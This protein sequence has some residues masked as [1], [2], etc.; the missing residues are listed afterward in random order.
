[1]KQLVCVL[2]A[3]VFTLVSGCA[4]YS[5]MAL[6][7]NP[8]DK[9]KVQVIEHVSK[10]ASSVRLFMLGGVPSAMELISKTVSEANGDGI[11]NLE[12]TLSEGFFGPLTFPKVAIEGD[13]VKVVDHAAQSIKPAMDILITDT[14]TS[15]ASPIPSVQTASKTKTLF[16]KMVGKIPEIGTNNSQGIAQPDS[17]ATYAIEAWKTAI[18]GLNN[19]D[20]I[21]E[22][23]YR[24]LRQT[25]QK[26]KFPAWA[27]G[28]T[29]QEY[30]H[31][32]QSKKPLVDWLL[33]YWARKGNEAEKARLGTTAP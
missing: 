3:V 18:L 27:A 14:T 20:V 21:Y 22:D 31:F 17:A 24:F 28:L 32:V 13:I 19:N 11:V 12:V 5:K 29:A 6:P 23:W 2:I 9:D 7:E 25:R 16:N 1:M 4:Y 30:E 8:I 10:S 33:Y 26:I 15:E